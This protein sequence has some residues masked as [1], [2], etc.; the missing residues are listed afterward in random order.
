M[1]TD[2][3]MPFRLHPAAF[4][5]V[6]R[7]AARNGIVINESDIQSVEDYHEAAFM[8]LDPKDAA[9]LEE[10][11]ETGGYPGMEENMARRAQEERELAA[12]AAKKPAEPVADE[13]AARRTAR[14]VS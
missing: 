3:N 8:G 10:F 12:Q 5:D 9:N 6:R 1:T 4:N 7:A 2:N 11:L 13:L 14:R